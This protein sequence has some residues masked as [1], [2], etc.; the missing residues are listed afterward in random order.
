MDTISDMLT[1]IRNAQAVGHETTVVPFS[2]LKMKIAEI[3]IEQG[4]IK[5]LKRIKR[6]Q[7][8]FIRLYLKY[9]DDGLPAISGLKR[10]SKPGQRIYKKA[11]EIRRIRHGYGISIISTSKDL[12]I[13]KEAK[14][15]K[16][17]GE[18]LCE[19]W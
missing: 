3:L 13:G 11:K 2:A 14:K 10:I 16:L 7:F 1:R 6:N 8:K 15:Q 18:V 17:G 12:L 9:T 19:I 4:F 5:D